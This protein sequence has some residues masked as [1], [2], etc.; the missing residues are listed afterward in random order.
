MRILLIIAGIVILVPVLLVA[1]AA[2]LLANPEYYEQ[3]LKDTVRQQTGFDV[4]INGEMTWRYFPPIALTI[5]DVDVRPAGADESLASLG[6]AEIDLGVLP[7]IFGGE[8]AVNALTFE[9]IAVNARVDASG[10]ANWDTGAAGAADS[11]DTSGSA[12]SA[13]RGDGPSSLSLDVS[14]AR[15]VDVTLSYIDESA[16]TEYRAQLDRFITDTIRFDAP[17]SA[18]FS[19]TLT[20]VSGGMAAEVVGSGL[21]TVTQGFGAMAFENLELEQQFTIPD[22]TP[23]SLDLTLNGRY[24]IAASR[25]ETQLSGQLDDTNIS[26][27]L[28]TDTSSA[29]TGVNFDL[30][31]ASLDVDRY[32]GGESEATPAESAPPVDAEVLPLET[33][34]G[35]AIDGA[36]SLGALTVSGYQFSDFN[37]NVTNRDNELTATMN[38]KGYGGD[39][40]VRFTAT[41]EGRGA[42]QASASLAGFDVQQFTGLEWITGTLNLESNTTF[43]GSMLSDVFNTLDGTS[44]FNLE[45]GTLDVRPVKQVAAVVDTLRGKQSSVA[46]WPDTMAFDNLNGEHRFVD[47]AQQNQTLRFA[48]EVLEGRGTGGFDYFGNSIDYNLILTMTE[49]EGPFSVGPALAGIEWPLRCA[50]ALDTPPAQL[51][52]P[53]RNSIQKV[54]TSAAENEIKRKGSEVI[55][56]KLGE[57]LKK[58]FGN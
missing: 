44:T 36:L 19:A 37:V 39:A 12:D 28:S 34:R 50:G 4:A 47:G 9:D 27:E 20:D 42:G 55:R 21:L 53:D 57:G 33:L 41:T 30:A 58:L 5:A 15:F 25:L 56:E 40:S 10:R 49:N 16:G 24:D 11:D 45:N 18:E 43:T 6:R 38:M 1:A 54:L 35:L 31:L 14:E 46:A 26:G 7:L 23:I 2:I 8:I 29:V 32:M 52:R 22:M 3:Q 51:C 48:L 17:A 13:D